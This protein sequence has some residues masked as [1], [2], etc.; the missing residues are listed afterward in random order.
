M[1]SKTVLKVVCAWCNKDLGEKDGGGNTGVSH[2]ICPACRDRI[3]REHEI[4]ESIQDYWKQ[5]GVFE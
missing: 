2:G 1:E 5:G 4:A 3:E